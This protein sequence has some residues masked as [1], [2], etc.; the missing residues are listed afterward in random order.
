[1]G[2]LD[3]LPGTSRWYSVD[4]RWP[5]RGKAKVME[6]GLDDVEAEE[7]RR[8]R[9]RRRRQRL[10][11]CCKSAAAFLFSHIGLAAMVVAYSIMGGFLFQ[12]SEPQ[13]LT[14]TC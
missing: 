5:G 11:A 2:G 13:K 10:T 4:G 3:A 6:A 14:K 1:V 8:E 12:A 9:R 7:L